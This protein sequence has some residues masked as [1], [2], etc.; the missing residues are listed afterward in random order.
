MGSNQDRVRTAGLERYRRSAHCWDALNVQDRI[1]SRFRSSMGS[2]TW[3]WRIGLIDTVASPA[4]IGPRVPARC[5]HWGVSGGFHVRRDDTGRTTIEFGRCL[6]PVVA[7]SARQKSDRAPLTANTSAH[8]RVQR[9]RLVDDD[10]FES[11]AHHGT[12]P[13]RRWGVMVQ[14]ARGRR[15]DRI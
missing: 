12:R 5:S 3:S 13:H 15:L 14:P 6:G 7:P 11:D 9:K 8:G 10:A 4:L 2:P 1:A